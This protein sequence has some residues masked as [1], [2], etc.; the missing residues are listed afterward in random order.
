MKKINLISL[1][2]LCL[3]SL[4]CSVIYGQKTI[5]VP[6][7]FTTI[8]AALLAAQDNDSIVVRPGT[9]FENLIWP[10]SAAYGIK[11]ISQGNASNTIIDGNQKGEVLV[12]EDDSWPFDTSRIDSNTIISGFTFRN[13]L[14]SGISIQY[15]SP[16]LS[17]LVV[18]NNVNNKDFANGGGIYVRNSTSQI[19]HCTIRNNKTVTPDWSYGAGIYISSS[20][21]KINDCKIIG[22]KSISTDGWA[23]GGGIYIAFEENELSTIKNCEISSNSVESPKWNYGGGLYISNY[24][25]ENEKINAFVENCIINDNKTGNGTWSYGSAVYIDA[26]VQL[27]NCVV[28]GNSCAQATRKA[29]TIDITRSFTSRFVDV[30]NC[31]IVNNNGPIDFEENSFGSIIN[32][33]VWNTSY[34]NSTNQIFSDVDS[35]VKVEFSIVK[36]G[37][38]GRGNISTKPDFVDEKLLIPSTAFIGINKGTNSVKL[39]FD[40]TGLARPFGGLTDIGAYEVVGEFKYVLVNFFFD[41]N[42]NG[43]KDEGENFL[44]QGSVQL[45]NER[46]Y[47][48]NGKSG[49]FTFISDGPHT[50]TYNDDLKNWRLTSN[51]TKVNFD[52]NAAFPYKEILFGLAPINKISNFSTLINLPPLRCN[53]QVVLRVSL[54]N[55][56]STDERGKLFLKIDPAFK[57]ISSNPKH[58]DYTG[59]SLLVWEYQDLPPFASLDF[60]VTIKVPGIQDSSDLE[61]I[62]TFKSWVSTINRDYPYFCIMDKIRCSFDPNDKMVNPSREDL[63]AL[64]TGDLVYTIRF[65]NTGNDY[66][67]D[68]LIVDSLDNN[69]DLRSFAVL[70][71]SHENRLTT[72]RIGNVIKFEFNDIYLPAKK[73]NERESKG[74]VTYRVK[75]LPNTDEN[76]F[77]DNTA[78]IY[79]DFNP[80]IVTNT[81]RSILVEKFPTSSTDIDY[82]N[83][84]AFP[85]PTTGIVY[86]TDAIDSATVF[87]SFGQVVL[88]SFNCKSLDLSSMTNGVYSVLL[89]K[90]NQK[91]LVKIVVN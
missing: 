71:T 12:I 36:D 66:A 29:T 46:T 57:L 16:S 84:S 32:S 47:F 19:S 69:L 50:I 26:N 5:Y 60:Y 40:I 6:D 49:V 21:V 72:T 10:K 80:A 34:N 87:N 24:N 45:D 39:P 86:F 25:D 81:T 73:V 4:V 43:I 62:Y 52:I 37:H 88:K 41:K 22:N 59:D 20:S 75:P 76:S 8:N 64:T 2:C 82:L 13:G 51:N 79:F 68:V 30:I 17:N 31:S 42:E 23:F 77:V 28:T 7:N 55:E 58:V 14:G 56:G 27:T 35:P 74:Y 18:E 70:S 78:Y 85:N 54:F 91:T 3:L 11:L 53:N 48:N 15:C 67:E 89:V 38:T 90:N 1:F 63:L 83:V 33:I 44:E 61:K 9:Y 65:E